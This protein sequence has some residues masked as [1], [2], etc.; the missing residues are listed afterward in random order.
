MYIFPRQF[1]LHNVFTSEVNFKE[2]SQRLKDYTLREEEIFEKF[3]RLNEPTTRIRTPKR[4]RGTAIELVRKLQILH[5]RCSYSKLLQ[6]YCPLHASLDRRELEP[7]EV[8][9][10]R[11][12]SRKV[13]VL[14]T[15]PALPSQAPIQSDPTS[16][17]FDLETP[18]AKIS[19]FCQAVLKKIVPN[20]FWGSGSVAE[21]N[22][23][24]FLKKVNH[25]I[26]LRRF[27]IDRDRLACT[28]LAQVE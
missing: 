26:L 23:T 14:R 19:A 10:T 8:S 12:L 1:R 28:T 6:Y 27:E 5:Q 20:Q 4:L 25:F 13:G 11:K 24:M 18:P 15:K 21:H 22:E 7:T 9:N 2:T 17:V 16:S 3:G